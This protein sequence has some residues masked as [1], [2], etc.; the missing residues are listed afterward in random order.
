M[1]HILKDLQ[2]T[3]QFAAEERIEPKRDEPLIFKFP[4]VIPKKKD[5]PG[6]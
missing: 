6:K 3:E 5:G 1:P 2:E 4:P